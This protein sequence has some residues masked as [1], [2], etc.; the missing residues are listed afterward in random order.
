MRAVRD[1]GGRVLGCDLDA[2]LLGRA[3]SAGPV[4]QCRLPDLDWIASGAVGGA[5]AVLVLEHLADHD[6]MFRSVYRTVAAG[7]V[8]VV[9]SNHPAFTAP[10]AGPLIDPTDGEVSWRWGRYLEPGTSIEPAGTVNLTMHHRPLGALLTSAAG[11]GWRLVQMEER[12]A[13]VLA[14]E[15]DP[16][17]G[18]QRHFP[19]LL[20]LRF[21]RP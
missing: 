14:M 1:S 20:G 8:L 12:G 11:A 19:R 6:A 4:V 13:G 21:E 18:A 3:R 9:L 15:R 5:Y 7:G 10:G 17:L 16:L 2:Q